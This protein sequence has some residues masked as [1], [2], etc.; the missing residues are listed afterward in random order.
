ML[1]SLPGKVLRGEREPPDFGAFD[2][3][4]LAHSLAPT[5]K[6]PNYGKAECASRRHAGRSLARSFVTGTCDRW[7]RSRPE[8]GASAGADGG[9]WR[10]VTCATTQRTF[11]S[12]R[13]SASVSSVTTAGRAPRPQET[14]TRGAYRVRPPCHCLILP[15]STH[16]GLK[17]PEE[18][19]EVATLDLAISSPPAESFVLGVTRRFS[20]IRL[21]RSLVNAHPVVGVVGRHADVVTTRWQRRLTTCTVAVRLARACRSSRTIEPLVGRRR[22]CASLPA[23]WPEE[24]GHS[25]C[26]CST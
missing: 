12:S 4:A 9:G 3:V 20:G 21:S 19:T 13:C 26:T 16:G 22:L 5:D 18:G 23:P 1:E 6:H 8:V 10:P 11:G 7:T 24:R 17:S 2:M 25:R 14:P 15:A